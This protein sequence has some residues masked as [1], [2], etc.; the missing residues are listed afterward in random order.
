MQWKGD[1][2]RGALVDDNI[3][4]SGSH[5]RVDHDRIELDHDGIDR[6]GRDRERAADRD[7]ADAVTDVR[8]V[9]PAGH[10]STHDS[11]GFAR[12]DQS[13]TRR[14]LG[15]PEPAIP[16]NDHRSREHGLTRDPQHH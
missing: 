15:D 7:F 16:V 12:V 14:L 9:R 6:A 13:S 3:T 5:D 2:A 1:P 10:A 4:V 11:A 8:A